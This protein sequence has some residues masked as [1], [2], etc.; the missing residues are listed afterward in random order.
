MTTSIS[1]EAVL[2]YKMYELQLV[3]MG[4]EKIAFLHFCAL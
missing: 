1:S 4:V 3:E 2:N